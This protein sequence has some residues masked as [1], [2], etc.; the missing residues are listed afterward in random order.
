[1]TK[2]A[3]VAAGIVTMGVTACG[4]GSV[5]DAA[6]DAYLAECPG[7]DLGTLVNGY[8][9]TTFDAKTLWTAYGTDDPDKVRVTAEGQVLFVGSPTKAT[10]EVIYDKARDELALSGVK[11]N[12][13]DQPKGLADALVSNM[14]DKAKGL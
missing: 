12:G 5:I 6:K 9:I 14:C 4:G 1:M 11:F 7:E 3:A 10:L 13:Q 8:Y 2:R